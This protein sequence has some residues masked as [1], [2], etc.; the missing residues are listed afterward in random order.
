MAMLSGCGGCLGGEPPVDANANPSAVPV[1]IVEGVV[2]LEAG[3]TLPEYQPPTNV[4]QPEPPKSCSPPKLVDRQPVGLEDGRGL[5]NIVIGATQFP[6]SPDFKPVAHDAAIRDCRL[7]PRVIAATRGD[8]IRLKN[9]A[10]YPFLPELGKARLLQMLLKGETREIKL[11]QPGILELG[12]GFAAACGR[13]DVMVFHHPVHTVSGKAGQFRMVNVPV[14][15]GIVLH[16]WHP[17]FQ[18]AS[19]KVNVEAGKVTRVEFVLS[20]VPPPG[21]AVVKTDPA[22]TPT[23]H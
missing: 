3:A 22:S 15:D 1:G 20:P 9:E 2:R 10:D 4:N 19:K 14:Q 17:L 13:T 7:E 8:T 5:S 6:R 21:A 16:A 12:C 18:G 23:L 11:E